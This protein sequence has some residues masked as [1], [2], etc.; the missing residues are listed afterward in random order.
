M[1]KLRGTV[2]EP[3]KEGETV[4]I[5][6]DVKKSQEPVEFRFSS[7]MCHKG[8]QVLSNGKEVKRIVAAGNWRSI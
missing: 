6:P 4:D 3:K 7:E 2:S 1:R 8:I 5:V